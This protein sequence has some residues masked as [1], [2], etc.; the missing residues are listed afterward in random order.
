MSASLLCRPSP[1]TYPANL[2]RR[3]ALEHTPD[4]ALALLLDVDAR[5]PLALGMALEGGDDEHPRQ[6]S[7]QPPQPQQP[8]QPPQPQP[9]Q[10]PQHP[11]QPP[12]SSPPPQRAS[13]PP[14]SQQVLPPQRLPPPLAAPLPAAQ[15]PTWRT[16]L[17][18][19]VHRTCRERGRF[20]VL[21]ALEVVPELLGAQVSIS[22]AALLEPS[23]ASAA[24]AA[25]NRH[26][27]LLRGF[28][29]YADCH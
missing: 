14:S 11:Q 16:A 21:P 13:S 2:M 1:S 18:A 17:R 28:H 23:S 4:A 6:Q 3:V 24:Q 9:Q 19:L 15:P 25:L 10:H 22:A 26:A 12:P 8:Q 29:R 5:P 27:E 7:Q 20:L